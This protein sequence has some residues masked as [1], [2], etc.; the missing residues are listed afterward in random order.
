MITLGAGRMQKEDDVDPLAGCFLHKRQ[1]DEVREGDVLATVYAS[2]DDRLSA[3]VDAL[4][5]AWAFTETVKAP[6][7]RIR[8]RYVDRSWSG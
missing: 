7:P 4:T 2:S 3:A 1:G 6:S 8:D 5:E